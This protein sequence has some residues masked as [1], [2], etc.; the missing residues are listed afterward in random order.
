[1]HNAIAGQIETLR[2]QIEHYE[3][4]RD[5]QITSREITSL[6]ELPTVLIEARIAA[7]RGPCSPSWRDTNSAGTCR[8]ACSELAY[9][10]KGEFW[11]SH[12]ARNGSMIFQRSLPVRSTRPRRARRGMALLAVVCAP[13]P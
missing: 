9:S 4:L 7:A 12:S 13:R 5:G 10:R 8:A 2:R 6:H 11:V 1:M 3:K